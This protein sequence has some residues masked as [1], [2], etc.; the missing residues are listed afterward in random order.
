MLFTF[1]EINEELFIKRKKFKVISKTTRDVRYFSRI[2]S[3]KL[4]KRPIDTKAI[5]L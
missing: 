1:N 4:V 2:V 5:E 3:H